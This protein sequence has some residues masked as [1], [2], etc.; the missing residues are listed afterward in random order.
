MTKKRIQ[1]TSCF[2]LNILRCERS[3]R[4]TFCIYVH[5]CIYVSNLWNLPNVS[6]QSHYQSYM[7]PIKRTLLFCL[8]HWTQLCSQTFRK[9]ATWVKDRPKGNTKT[10]LLE[11]FFTHGSLNLNV[12]VLFLVHSQESPHRQPFHEVNKF[13]EGKGN[14]TKQRNQRKGVVR[15][16]LWSV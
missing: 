5:T 7:C 16:P 14:F 2:G 9:Q 10:A 8:E 13:M 4:V 12:T 15:I 11:C 1:H 6:D 3:H